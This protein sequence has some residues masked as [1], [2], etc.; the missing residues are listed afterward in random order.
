MNHR[1]ASE[2]S[3]HLLRDYDIVPIDYRHQD[4]AEV[5]RARHPEGVRIVYDHLGGAALRASHR[6]LAPGGV[7]VSY[8]FMG[9]PGHVLADTVRGAL[10]NRVLNLVPGRRT[11]ICSPPREI[12]TDPPR[13][14][15][16]LTGLFE[17]ALTQLIRPRIGVCLPLA[18]AADAIGC[19]NGGKSTERS[20][21][22]CS[23]AGA[24]V[25]P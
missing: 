3:L 9:R 5:V 10:H 2:R 20:S 19:S 23:E 4:A 14:Q 16:L 6:L 13:H 15:A 25:V 22:P 1:D 7:L 24:E 17:L 21:S 12:A 8:A 11:A 18:R